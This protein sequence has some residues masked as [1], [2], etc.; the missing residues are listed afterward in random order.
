VAQLVDFET[1]LTSISFL[2]HGCIYFRKEL[3]NNNIKAYDLG[4]K[5]LASGDC[6][7]GGPIE[8]FA[9]GPFTEARMW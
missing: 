9:F 1:K 5:S 2:R 8:E 7:K 3:E 4:A 6:I